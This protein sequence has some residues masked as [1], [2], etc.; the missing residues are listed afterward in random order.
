MV[1]VDGNLDLYEQ[2]KAQK[3]KFD[4]LVG[5]GLHWDKATKD[6]W[7]QLMIVGAD[8]AERERWPEYFAWLAERALQLRAAVLECVK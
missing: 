3:D 7:A 2:L 8:P 1:Y 6:G 5:E 4:R